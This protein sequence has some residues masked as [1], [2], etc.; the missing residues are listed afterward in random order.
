MKKLFALVLALLMLCACGVPEQPE[1][2]EPGSNGP[3]AP[4]DSEQENELGEG[5]RI[6]ENCVFKTAEGKYGIQKDGKI[7]FEPVYDVFKTVG[8]IGKRT[9]YALGKT[10]GTKSVISY[11]EDS[12]INGTEETERILFEFFFDDGTL[13][14]SIPADSYEFYNW[15]NVVYENDTLLI[16][17]EGNR[18][19]YEFSREGEI[20]SDKSEPAGKTGAIFNGLEEVEYF[21]FA[22]D[23]G[24]GL[25]LVDGEENVVIPAIYDKI[26]APFDDRIVAKRSDGGLGVGTAR[27][28]DNEGNIIS[29]KFHII[30]FTE[31]PDGR[32]IGIAYC[33]GIESQTAVVCRDENGEIMEKG[34]RFIDK[35]GK[36]LSEPFE[37]DD[38]NAIQ[39]GGITPGEYMINA[40]DENGNEMEINISDYAFEH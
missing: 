1:I 36:E 10:E 3:S 26:T 15:D 16:S 6:L 4:V 19:I 23:F 7:V 25:G 39:K 27:I 9:L 21:Y 8:K 29:D 31:L 18:Y 24:K 2:N 17:L 34:W 5:S 12:R 20:I 33:A 22:G 11:N 37:T 40:A 35:D 38:F 13:L 32:F 14:L 28:F 30:E